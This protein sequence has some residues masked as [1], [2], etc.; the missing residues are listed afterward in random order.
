MVIPFI[1]FPMAEQRISSALAG[2]IN[3][4][5]PLFAALSPLSSSREPR[6]ASSSRVCWWEARCVF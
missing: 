2:M 6:V 3:G 5:V 4:A 1:L